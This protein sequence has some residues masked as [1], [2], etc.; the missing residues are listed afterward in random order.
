MVVVAAIIVIA[1]LVVMTAGWAKPVVALG[2]ALVIAGLLGIAPASELFGGLSNSG[3]LTVGAMLVIAKGIV[4]TGA[5]ARTTRKLLRKAHTAEGALLRLALP[6]GAASG[7]MNTTPI[8]AMLIPASKQ[9]EQTRGIPAREVMLPIAHLTT[10]AGSITL[11][12]TSSNLLIAGM[13]ADRGVDMGMLSFAPIALPVAVVGVVV[14][15]LTARL[16]GRKGR[17]P[18]LEKPTWRVEI[19][20]GDNALVR[21]RSA[22]Q[23]GL[24]SARDYRL[25]AIRRD[26]ETLPRDAALEAGDL[27]IFK[28]T[29]PGVT[30]LWASPHLGL[31]AQRLYAVSLNT[32]VSGVLAELDEDRGLEVIAAQTRGPLNATPIVPGATCYVTAT[33]EEMLDESEHV[34]LWQDKAGSAPQPR[35]TWTALGILALVVLSASFG[36]APIEF[37]SIGGALLMVITGVLP[38]RSAARALDWNV[39]FILAGSVG[40]GAIVLASGLADILASAIRSL[41]GG[42]EVLVIIVFAVMTTL[43]TNVISNAAAASILTPVAITVAAAS[44]VSPVILLALV[45]TCI[46]FTFLNPYS[47]QTNLMVIGPIGYSTGQFVMYGVPVL[48]TGLVVACAV[49]VAL[50]S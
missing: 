25:L 12:G 14:V 28:A 41:A 27:L 15:I 43:L 30:V 37:T 29:E 23:V 47:H 49:G 42:S 2:V 40:L 33:S 8:V 38:A 45:G 19:V 10:L 46:S 48:L 5:V 3:V 6:V 22:A 24:D 1:T 32:G 17:T 44:S 36:L 21:G 13:A 34:S 16:L 20:V 7:L 31:A 4:Q 26:G 11:I 9:L 50:T 39:L 18:A 35:Q